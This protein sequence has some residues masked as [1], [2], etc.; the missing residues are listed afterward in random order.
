[1]GPRGEVAAP[2]ERTGTAGEVLTVKQTASIDHVCAL[3]QRLRSPLIPFRN[4][5]TS[6]V[7]RGWSPEILNMQTTG[8]IQWG[9]SERGKKAVALGTVLSSALGWLSPSFAL[10]PPRSQRLHHDAL[11]TPGRRPPPSAPPPAAPSSSASSPPPQLSGGRGGQSAR[12]RRQ[13]RGEPRGAQSR[14]PI[15]TRRQKAQGGDWSRP[16]ATTGKATAKAAAGACSVA[17]LIHQEHQVR[18]ASPGGCP[19]AALLSPAFGG[20][21]LRH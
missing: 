5:E 7:G 3:H 9:E 21:L 20:L 19:A 2:R 14:D 18:A 11:I 17:G 4:G 10:S 12:G 8:K 16:T 15:W 6:W 1:M 13:A